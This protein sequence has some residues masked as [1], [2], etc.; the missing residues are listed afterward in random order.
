MMKLKSART[1]M[2]IILIF[3]CGWVAVVGLVIK[4]SMG[5]GIALSL[6][7]GAAIGCLVAYLIRRWWFKA[8]AL[9]IDVKRVSR[10]CSWPLGTD[11]QKGPTRW[12]YGCAGEDLKKGMLVEADLAGRITPPPEIGAVQITADMIWGNVKAAKEIDP[13]GINVLGWPEVKVKKGWYCWLRQ[14]PV[15]AEFVKES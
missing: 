6:A 15:G 5:V 3:V 10:V 11:F 12:R 4:P 7:G 13:K 1:L 14:P 9:W 8:R 2:A